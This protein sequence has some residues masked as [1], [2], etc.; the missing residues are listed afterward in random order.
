MKLENR[1]RA[2]DRKKGGYNRNK[3]SA[4]ANSKESLNSRGRK[5]LQG[6]I[7]GR[8]ILDGIWKI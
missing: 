6:A 3:I 2:G 7:M 1:G 8:H 5:N 4:K